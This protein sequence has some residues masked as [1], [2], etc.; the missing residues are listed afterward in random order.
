MDDRR[1]DFSALDPGQDA[2][3]FERMVQA[4]LGRSAE[5]QGESMASALVARGRVFV[6]AAAAMAVLVWIPLL[7]TR[8][9]ATVEVKSTD[10]LALVSTW[11]QQGSI[12]DGVDVFHVLG[13]NN[14]R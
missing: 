11:A 7:A 8:D 10:P 6:A 5:P 14:A 3:R 4:V 13:V 1:I 9:T 12:P 2:E